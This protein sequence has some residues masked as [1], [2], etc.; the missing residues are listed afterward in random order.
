MNMNEDKI[1]EKKSLNECI[2]QKLKHKWQRELFSWFLALSQA[3]AIVFIV[4]T[5]IFEPVRVSGSSMANTLQNNE[6]LIAT[7]FDYFLVE[8]SRFDIVICKYPNRK[9]N[10]VKRIV[11]LPGDVISIQNG[12]LSVNGVTYPEE[13]I[14]NRPNYTVK[15]YRVPEDSYYVLGDNRTNSNDSHII[16]SISRSQI[17]AHVRFVI[18]PFHSIRSVELKNEEIR[19]VQE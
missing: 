19:A 5:F 9:E 4:Y 16:G 11:G 14:A 18:F 10:F 8:P 17:I 12:L 1:L 2:H 7:K 15:E 3:F 13:H 6:I